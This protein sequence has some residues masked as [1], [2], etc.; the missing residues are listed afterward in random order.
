MNYKTLA[1]A[2]LFSIA[3]TSAAFAQCT[4]C[5]LYPDRDVLNKGAPTPAS[6]MMEQPGGAAAYN[7]PAGARVADESVGGTQRRHYRDAHASIAEGVAPS[8]R[9]YMK[10]LHDS[11]YSPSGDFNGAGN[12]KVN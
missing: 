6:K 3:L 7:A 10:N 1:A 8:Q 12:M 11:G 4:E 2:S 9:V 5:A